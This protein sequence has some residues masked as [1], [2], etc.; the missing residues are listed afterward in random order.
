MVCSYPLEVWSSADSLLFSFVLDVIHEPL[1]VFLVSLFF[2]GQFR[3]IKKTVPPLLPSLHFSYFDE[4]VCSSAKSEYF[5]VGYL[6]GEVK[7]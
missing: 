4:K 7:L 2:N 5:Q 3:K 6:G 1:S